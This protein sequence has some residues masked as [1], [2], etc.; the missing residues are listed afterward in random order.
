M[1]ILNVQVF[2]SLTIWTTISYTWCL[3]PALQEYRIVGGTAVYWP[4]DR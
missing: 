3:A 1:T 4:R 2:S